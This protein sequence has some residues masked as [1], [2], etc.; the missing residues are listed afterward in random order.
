MG[1][2]RKFENGVV[3]QRDYRWRRRLATLPPL[4]QLHARAALVHQ[5]VATAAASGEPKAQEILGRDYQETAL[6]LLVG[7]GTK[8]LE[9]MG[10]PVPLL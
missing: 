5:V 9:E 6:R 8:H 3:K 1:R 10:V 4:A 7:A 2:P